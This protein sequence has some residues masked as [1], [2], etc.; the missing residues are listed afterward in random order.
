MN[1]TKPVIRCFNVKYSPNLGDGLLSECLEAALIDAGAHPTSSS[2]DLAARQEYGDAMLGRG[3]IMKVLDAMPA[4]LR[5]QAVRVPL[6]LHGAMKWRPHYTAALSDADGAVLGGGNLLSDLDLNFPTKIALAFDEAAKRDVPMAVYACGVGSGWSKQGLKLGRRAFAHPQLQAVFVRDAA[7]AAL[8]DQMFADATGHQAQIVRD[9]GL[10][11]ATYHP[12]APK[13]QTARLIAGL[14]I[15]SHL[16]IRYHAAN[17]PNLAQL[18]AFY[19]EVARGL[20]AAGYQVRAFTNGSPE[21][22]H[23]CAELYDRLRALGGEDALTFLTQ[24]DPAGLCAHISQFDVLIAYRMHAV[25]AAYSYAIPMIALAW[26]RKLASFM[27]SVDLSDNLLDVA[28]T[29]AADCV[30]RTVA[31]HKAG[32]PLDKHSAVLAE[33]AQDVRRLWQCFA[34]STSDQSASL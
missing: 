19:I 16:A 1:L 17:A 30:A 31:A 21:D 32:L 18:D 2:A 5:K 29:S 15:M 33:A 23:Y 10:L 11:S 22:Q 7:S 26:D 14:N 12:A 25:I 27:D 34:P 8:F 24:A 20:I 9:P 6:A 28:S 3:A 13:A 4:P